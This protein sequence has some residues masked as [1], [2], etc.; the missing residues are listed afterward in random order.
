MILS[1]RGQSRQCAS[2][3]TPGSSPAA[4]KVARLAGAALLLGLCTSHIRQAASCQLAPL[5]MGDRSRPDCSGESGRAVGAVLMFWEQASHIV[6]AAAL[7][8]K[9]QA[10]CTARQ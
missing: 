9:L 10:S 2:R 4:A 7:A 6:P 1:S 3:A 5:N 8:A